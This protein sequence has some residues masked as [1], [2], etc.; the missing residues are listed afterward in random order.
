MGKV[1]KGRRKETRRSKRSYTVGS[2]KRQHFIKAIQIYMNKTQ[3]ICHH[4]NG[5]ENQQFF[6]HAFL[7]I[8]LELFFT[9]EEPWK[10]L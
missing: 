5:E 2:T 7:P 1:I 8:T 3:K 10:K 6:K 4:I 9:L